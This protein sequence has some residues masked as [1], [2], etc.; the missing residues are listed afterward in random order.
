MVAA[1][2][3]VALVRANRLGHTIVHDGLSLSCAGSHLEPWEVLV[4]RSSHVYLTILI[5]HV[6]AWVRAHAL[7]L[8]HGIS[9]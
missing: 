8:C 5:L 6:T 4:G 7:L 3:D 1:V 9:E 2:L